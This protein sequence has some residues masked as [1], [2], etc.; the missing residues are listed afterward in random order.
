MHFIYLFRAVFLTKHRLGTEQL[1]SGCH[2]DCILERASNRWFHDT[3][4]TT[5]MGLWRLST[6]QNQH[7]AGFPHGAVCSMCHT[8]SISAPLLAA[9][10]F[11]CL[12]HRCQC[13]KITRFHE[14]C[15]EIKSV[16]IITYLHGIKSVPFTK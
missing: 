12:I 11:C 7:F 4:H 10:L 6:P 15:P 16:A 9:G 1:E 8:Y 2:C 13:F 5:S 14:I 3:Y